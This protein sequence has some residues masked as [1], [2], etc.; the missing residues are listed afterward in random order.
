M[1]DLDFAELSERFDEILD[2]VERGA[3]FRVFRNGRPIAWLKRSD[4]WYPEQLDDPAS[5]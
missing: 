1:T 4:G 3:S 5:A 2:A